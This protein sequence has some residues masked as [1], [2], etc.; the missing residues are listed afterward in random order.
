V[1]YE[2]GAE[3]DPISVS[4]LMKKLFAAG[5]SYTNWRMAI[6]LVKASH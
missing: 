6:V 4:I 2:N 3:F 1:R 5:C